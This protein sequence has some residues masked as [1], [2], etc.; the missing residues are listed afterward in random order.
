VD[1]GAPKHGFLHISD[2]LPEHFPSGRSGTERVGKKVSRKDRP[3]IQECLRRGQE[4][5]CQITKDGIG[6][7]GPTLTTYLS[8]P[9]RF[10]VM[11]PGMTRNGVSRRIED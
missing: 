2:V 8:V 3:P 7:K 11:M 1:Y 6:T 5:I 10:V 4:V 9:G